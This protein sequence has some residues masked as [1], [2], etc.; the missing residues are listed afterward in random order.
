MSSILLWLRP[1]EALDEH[2]DRGDAGAGDFGG[3]VEGAGNWKSAV[4]GQKLEFFLRFFQS[5][6]SFST[7]NFTV[8][9]RILALAEWSKPRTTVRF[10]VMVAPSPPPS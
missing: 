4:G 6:Y 9:L 8:D 7:A 3:V 2:H 5:V 1:V 10:A